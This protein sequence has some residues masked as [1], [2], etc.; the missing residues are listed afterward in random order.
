MAQ[1]DYRLPDS[2]EVPESAGYCELRA[3]SVVSVG[4][5]I[6]GDQILTFV[7]T[8]NFPVLEFKNGELALK[9]LEKKKVASV[10][11]GHNQAKMFY[12]SLK[13]I[14]DTEQD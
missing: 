7:F 14:F 2:D 13:S 3:D 4:T 9:T 6:E 1:Q 8:N 10:T 12:D 11:M 5:N